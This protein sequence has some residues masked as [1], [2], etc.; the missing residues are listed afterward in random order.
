[1]FNKKGYISDL[2]K[3][4]AEYD[5]KPEA[6]SLSRKLEE[7]KYKKVFDLRDNVKELNSDKNIWEGF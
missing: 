2:G 7:K 6:T 1:M 5:K 4:L 3:F